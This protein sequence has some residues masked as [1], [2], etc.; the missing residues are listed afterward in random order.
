MS[1]S[2]PSYPENWADIRQVALRRDGHRCR[3]CG[4]SANLNVHHIVPL[5]RGGT[6]DLYNLATL[7]LRC[8]SGVHPHMRARHFRRRRARLSVPGLALVFFISILLTAVIVGASW[9]PYYFTDPPSCSGMTSD[10]VCSQ[11]SQVNASLNSQTSNTGKMIS[12]GL[13]TGILG[14]LL[15]LVW[16]PFS[17]RRTRNLT[18]ATTYSEN[19]LSEGSRRGLNG[20]HGWSDHESNS[21]CPSC[22]SALPLGSMD[23]TS[24]GWVA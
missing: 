5:S 2:F 23:C 22:S 10:P 24:C 17:V 19:N 3:K 18:L 14:T 21:R 12:F 8:H 11:I 20:R 4:S 6:N 9:H 15:S 13:W 16:L 7:C 1:W